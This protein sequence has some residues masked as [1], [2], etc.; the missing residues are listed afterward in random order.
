MELTEDNLDEAG[1]R[2]QRLL[3]VFRGPEVEKVVGA[4][5]GFLYILPPVT[6]F[7]QLQP[8]IQTHPLKAETTFLPSGE[9]HPNTAQC[10]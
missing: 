8:R 10:C 3:P 2:E 7:M 6:N 1:T 9:P 5:V 4:M